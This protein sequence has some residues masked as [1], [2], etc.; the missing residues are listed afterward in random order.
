MRHISVIQQHYLGQFKCE[1]ILSV[2]PFG[3]NVSNQVT[4]RSH[5]RGQSRVEKY[6]SI[7]VDVRCYLESV[8]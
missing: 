7:Q 3:I 1:A 6:S 5:S 2:S 8:V 4:S